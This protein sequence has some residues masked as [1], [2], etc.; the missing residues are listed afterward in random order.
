MTD[1][2]P[3]R[4]SRI[5]IGLVT[6][7][8]A[9]LAGCTAT[10]RYPTDP[11]VAPG[12]GLEAVAPRYPID[13]SPA[14]EPESR[15]PRDD[16][17]MRPRALAA[18]PMGSTV[19]DRSVDEAPLAPVLSRRDRAQTSFSEPTPTREAQEAPPKVRV[20]RIPGA[21][22]YTLVWG[23]TL[24]GVA[25]RFGVGPVALAFDNGLKK[26]ESLQ[27]GLRLRLPVDSHDGGEQT[28][29]TGAASRAPAR[30]VAVATPVARRSETPARARRDAATA[31]TDGPIPYDQLVG[32][33]R[34][35]AHR[36]R[37]PA[38]ASTPAPSDRAEIAPAPIER[39]AEA[40]DG[41]VA[42]ARGRFIRPVR[43]E[44]LSTFGV[45]GP[46]QRNDGVDLA[47]REG[48]TV[49]ASASGVV[50]YA[51]HDVPALGNLVA[52]KHANGWVTVYGNL[53]KITVKATER[54][55]QGAPLGV[56][57]ATSVTPTPQVH[58]E[59][60]Y[61]ADPSEKAHPVDPDLVL[62]KTG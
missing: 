32:R 34:T 60:R 56:A 6:L 13:G 39:D 53:E 24:Y 46:G 27:P 41:A 33:D 45:K 3:Y 21:L 23:D 9:S 19:S 26:G 43:G 25:R 15:T 62:P 28:H 44:T 8:L 4:R 5:G 12:S 40:D 18:A 31:P 59:V 29:A 36:D 17:P 11:G 30:A 37:A 52:V 57:G 61:A 58:F 35:H 42:G 47:A 7:G 1:P 38:S 49:R 50:V 22:T 20:R 14:P 2:S 10:P 16:A 48:E 54:L 51:G 55:V